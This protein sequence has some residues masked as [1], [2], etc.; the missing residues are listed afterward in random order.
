MSRSSVI[1]KQTTLTGKAR[2]ENTLE[3]IAKCN[4]AK[5][6]RVGSGAKGSNSVF[7]RVSPSKEEAEVSIQPVAGPRRMSSRGHASLRVNRT[8]DENIEG[9]ILYNTNCYSISIMLR[10]QVKNY[11]LFTL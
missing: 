2:R 3:K 5:E 8:L 1:L 9:T 7:T 4:K 6:D 11:N 10:S